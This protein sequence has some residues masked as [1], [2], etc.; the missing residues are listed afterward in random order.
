MLTFTGIVLLPLKLF[1]LFFLL[2]R[3]TPSLFRHYPE[4]ASTSGTKTSHTTIDFFCSVCRLSKR[5]LSAFFFVL[6]SMNGEISASGCFV[7]RLCCYLNTPNVTASD[8][9][10]SEI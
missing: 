3:W 1:S 5:N 8:R 10:K 9:S 6:N 4:S 2:T 7:F